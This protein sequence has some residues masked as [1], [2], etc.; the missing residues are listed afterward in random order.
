MSL[1]GYETLGI[2]KGQTSILIPIL[3]LTI[4]NTALLIAIT[5]CNKRGSL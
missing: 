4:F 5:I 1:I 2:I 3:L